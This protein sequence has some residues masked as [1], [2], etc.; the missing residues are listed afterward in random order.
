MYRTPFM[1]GY[2]IRGLLPSLFC[3]QACK[4][5]Y[6]TWKTPTSLP[7]VVWGLTPYAC[8]LLFVIIRVA[9]WDKQPWLRAARGNR[10]DW[11]RGSHSSD[12]VPIIAFNDE[13]LSTTDSCLNPLS[14]DK[15]QDSKAPRSTT[16]ELS[17]GILFGIKERDINLDL[18]Y[19]NAC[20]GYYVQYF[21]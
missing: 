11:F 9:C 8:K 7:A 5:Q 1:V 16:W 19:L 15:D 4:V 18:W 17:D 14:T 13:L 10:M 21:T 6:S 20:L 3:G 2:Q 12:M